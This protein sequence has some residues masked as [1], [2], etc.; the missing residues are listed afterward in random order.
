MLFLTGSLRARSKNERRCSHQIQ[1]RRL[2]CS[3]ACTYWLLLIL[4][5]HSGAGIAGLAFASFLSKSDDITVDVFEVKPEIR[6]IGA[7]IA[8]WKRYWDVLQDLHGFEEQCAERGVTTP[9]WS[10]GMGVSFCLG[11]LES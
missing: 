4:D 10:R 2:V 3:R 7:G 8:I 5:A 6:T 1:S 11:R 9:E